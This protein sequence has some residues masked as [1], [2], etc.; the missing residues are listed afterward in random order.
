M[1]HRM[2]LIAAHQMALTHHS[3]GGS[4]KP[5]DHFMVATPKFEEELT[6]EEAMTSWD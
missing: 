5:L 3:A 4:E 1:Q 6:L 2:E